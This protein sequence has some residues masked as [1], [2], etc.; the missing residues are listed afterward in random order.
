MDFSSEKLLL[1]LLRAEQRLLVCDCSGNC[2]CSRCATSSSEI[3][4]AQML[5]FGTN[6]C[7]NVPS[8]GTDNPQR[9]LA[10]GHDCHLRQA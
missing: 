2:T 10:D 3:D 5:P 4:F 9:S 6:T 8:T 7:R 1:Q